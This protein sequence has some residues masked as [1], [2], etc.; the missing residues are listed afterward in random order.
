MVHVP[1]RGEG[2][3]VN[4]LLTKSVSIGLSSVATA[5]PHALAGKLTPLAVIGRERSSALPNVPTLRELGF[6][7]PLYAMSV[8]MGFLVPAKTPPAIV[9]R[10]ADEIIA[11]ANAPDVRQSLIDRGFEMMVTTPGQFAQNYGAD[12]E[13]ITSRIREL[14]IEAQ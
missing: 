3:V 9:R 7:D 12:F 11:V 10:L 14:N 6:A 5:K 4:D 8:W 13:V 1:Q 2:P